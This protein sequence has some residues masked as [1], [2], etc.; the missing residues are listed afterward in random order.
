L[1]KNISGSR[2]D[3]RR[4]MR[5]PRMKWLEDV[6]NYLGEPKGKRC[7][8]E[9]SNSETWSCHKGD[10]GSQRTMKPRKYKHLIKMT[11]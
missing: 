2:S 6:E 9:A 7:R 5:R 8:E 3:R 10:Q 1:S 11:K 4:N